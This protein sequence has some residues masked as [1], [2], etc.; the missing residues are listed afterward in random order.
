M[1]K[2]YIIRKDELRKK[3]RRDFHRPTR[4]ERDPKAYSRKEKHRTFHFEIEAEQVSGV[5]VELVDT[6]DLKSCD[7]LVVWVRFPL[8]PPFFYER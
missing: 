4:A 2:N 7:R 3:V 6:P 8:T 5:M 1:E